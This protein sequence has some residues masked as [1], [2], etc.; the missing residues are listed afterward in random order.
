MFKRA[1][2]FLMLWI[3]LL[4]HAQNIPAL[5]KVNI[6]FAP[7]GPYHVDFL[8]GTGDAGDR[9]V[10]QGFPENNRPKPVALEGSKDGL[11]GSKTGQDIA[12]LYC[13]WNRGILHQR[14]R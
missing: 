6:P 3:A 4:V 11:E 9:P 14:S 5:I 2:S 7:G 12:E 1:L 13:A 10:Q 8:I